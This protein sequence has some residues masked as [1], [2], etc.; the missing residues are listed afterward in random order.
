MQRR[1]PRRAHGVSLI[2]ALVAL[3][4]MAFG[5]VAFVGLQSTL[6]H[7]GDVAKQRAEAV[8]IAQEAIERWRSYALLSDHADETDYAEIVATAETEVADVATNTTF[9]IER[10]VVD[11][12][13]AHDEPAAND[14]APRLKTLVVDVRW[15]DRAGEEQ[16]VRLS[17]AIA[18]TP[19][20]LAGTL[21][22]PGRGDQNL[23]PLARHPAIP[24]EAVDEGATSRFTPPQP[25][26]GTVTWV[27]DDRTGVI[28]SVCSAPDACVATTS[29]LLSGYVRFAT[30]S[31]QPTGADAETPPSPALP[32]GVIVNRTYP[33]DLAIACYE[34]V[35]TADVRY[36][37]AVPV[38][39]G[40]DPPPPRWAG[41][42]VIDGLDL[43][44]DLADSDP[45]RYRVC[46]YTPYRDHRHAGDG[47]PPMRNDQHPRDYGG[48]NP[49]DPVQGPKE[50]VTGPLTN[51]NFLVIRAGD[52]SVAFDCPDDDT[53]TALI[54][55]TTWRH[56]PSGA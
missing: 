41:R 20:E 12:A 43:A 55:G 25:P 34:Q 35:R 27:F 53:G 30:G 29:F 46:R 21:G 11:A 49:G 28:T 48:D 8:R 22:V 40:E 38:N 6:R 23:H 32:V 33:G 36:Y 42:S 37:C 4:V 54:D 14:G 18:A 24:V 51:Q 1:N 16:R 10:S 17:T 52:G 19:P 3:A 2:E 15:N 56:Q 47:V 31:V 50:G 26:G 13:I 39:P 5:M 45:D 7:N 9:R 44:T